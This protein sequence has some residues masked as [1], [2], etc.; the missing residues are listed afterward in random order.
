MSLT[1]VTQHTPTRAAMPDATHP[2][3]IVFKI[4]TVTQWSDAVAR[5]AFDGSKDDQR[6]GFIHLSAAHQLTGTL[7]KHFHGQPDLVL[8]AFSTADLGA[9]LKWEVSRGGEPFPH[10]YAPLATRLALW[11]KPLVLDRHGLPQV[12]GIAG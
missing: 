3:T 8:I 5:G 11:T 1:L 7:T 2:H 9:D 10:L 4:A 6:D 12:P